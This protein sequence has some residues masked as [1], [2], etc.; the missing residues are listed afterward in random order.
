[1][2]THDKKKN[3]NVFIKATNDKN[4]HN[5]KSSC[6]LLDYKFQFYKIQTIRKYNN[7]NKN[8]DKLYFEH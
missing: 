2:F 3:D 1:M 4:I 8:T 5:F 7:N 6:N